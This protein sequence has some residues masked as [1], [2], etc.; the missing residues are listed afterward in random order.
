MLAASNIIGDRKAADHPLSAGLAGTM[1]GP[2]PLLKSC[3][4][5]EQAPITAAPPMANG[6]SS[7]AID[8]EAEKI[9]VKKA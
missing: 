9:P 4:S 1:E 7:H 6:I 3:D 8:V 2:G 5:S